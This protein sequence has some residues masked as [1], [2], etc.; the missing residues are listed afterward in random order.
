MT[1]SSGSIKYRDPDLV[2]KFWAVVSIFCVAAG[3]ALL[4]LMFEKFGTKNDPFLGASF[5]ELIS[6]F[7][8]LICLIYI[9]RSTD[10]NPNETRDPDKMAVAAWMSYKRKP[11]GIF[12]SKYTWIMTLGQLQWLF[13]LWSSQFIDTVVTMI[14]F[15]MWPLWLILFFGFYQFIKNDTPDI[16]RENIRYLETNNIIDIHKNKITRKTK[17]FRQYIIFIIVGY[18][19]FIL[20]VFSQID[21][22]IDYLSSD[23]YTLIMGIVLA[24]IAGIMSTVSAVY[25]KLAGELMPK[26]TRQHDRSDPHL[27][28]ENLGAEPSHFRFV[29]TTSLIYTVT[30]RGILGI[31]LLLTSIVTNIFNTP[32]STSSHSFADFVL[33]GIS[34]GIVAVL[35]FWASIVDDGFK[36]TSI[37]Y[38]SEVSTNVLRPFISIGLLWLFTDIIIQRAD[39]FWLGVAAILIGNIYLNF[40]PDKGAHRNVEH[41]PIAIRASVIALWAFASFIILRDKLFFNLEMK[42]GI[43]EY[44]GLI[45]VCATV[46]ILLLSFRINRLNQREHYE[47]SEFLHLHRYAEHYYENNILIEED[48]FRNDK[49]NLNLSQDSDLASDLPDESQVLEKLEWFDELDLSPVTELLKR[50]KKLDLFDLLDYLHLLIGWYNLADLLVLSEWLDKHNRK[51]EQEL[52]KWLDMHN[53]KIDRLKLHALLEIVKLFYDSDLNR[54]LLKHLQWLNESSDINNI[55]KHYLRCRRI[56][57]GAYLEILK[58]RSLSD[59]E[60]NDRATSLLDFQIRLDRFANERQSGRDF[61]E[62][63]ALIMF[64]VLT[65]FVLL[66]ARPEQPPGSVSAW[67][68][69]VTEVAIS[70]FSATIFFLCVNLLDRRRYRDSSRIRK[71]TQDSI[72]KYSQPPGWRFNFWSYKDLV[73]DRMVS[74]IMGLTVLS[75]IVVSLGFKWF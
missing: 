16:I 48:I 18:I 61:A 13:F 23:L 22:S 10:K 73:R 17:I 37:R 33:V 24:I 7:A 71:V 56:V 14:L 42:W 53:L 45:S 32:T 70:I 51:D 59:R 66:L 38:Y 9:V 74:G 29:S 28:L 54:P 3:H 30:I 64:A 55:T 47:E 58:Y 39:I 4:P 11:F 2:Y 63:A 19:G 31:V 75:A 52:L 15:E 26:K 27:D 43:S 50:I 5:I 65:I 21:N 41:S 44:W 67:P 6:S 60:S 36:Y 12:K 1:D 62:F 20:I 68:S 35:L 40:D 72:Y 46:F 49:L 8:L 25:G 69:F 34:G 57:W